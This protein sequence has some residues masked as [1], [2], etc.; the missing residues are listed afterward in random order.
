MANALNLLPQIAP[1]VAR[2]VAAYVELAAADAKQQALLLS[3]RLM[4]AAVALLG[5][6]FA[7]LLSCAWIVATV[8][9]SPWRSQALA[10]LIMLFVVTA[11]VGAL[12]ATRRGDAASETRSNLQTEW[13]S[14]QNLIQELS[15]KA[16]DAG[17]PAVPPLERLQQ[18]RRELR[19]LLVGADGDGEKGKFPRSTTMRLLNLIPVASITR[20]LLKR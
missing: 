4:A 2:H 7:L 20:M 17:A 6:T 8:W 13:T 19:V 18:S 10:A 14:D 1:V 11:A 16:A 3:R 12:I 15:G 9:D 5:A